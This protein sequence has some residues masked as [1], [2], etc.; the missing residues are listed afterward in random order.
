MKFW[1]NVLA[2]LLLYNLGFAQILSYHFDQCE[3][4][5]IG[6]V[7]V[8]ATLVGN[9]DCV[10]GIGDNSFS[11]D[12]INDGIVVSDTFNKYLGEE[13]TVDFYFQWQHHECWSQ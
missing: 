6:Q 1:F 10:C 8:D 11:L 13:F 2:F 4:N 5:S 7:A 3:I 12:G 9:P